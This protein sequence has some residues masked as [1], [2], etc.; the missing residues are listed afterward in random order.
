MTTGILLAAAW[1]PTAPAPVVERREHDAVDVPIDEILDDLD[2][3]F[4][5]VFL[6]RALP[7]DVDAQFVRPP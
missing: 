2:L 3:L 4:A 1:R 6:Q 7:D 5:V